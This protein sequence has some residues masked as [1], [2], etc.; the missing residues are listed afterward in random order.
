MTQLAPGLGAVQLMVT[1]ALVTPAALRPVGAPGSAGGA[2]ADKEDLELEEGIAPLRWAG[3][4]HADVTAGSRDSEIIDRS[5][6]RWW[7]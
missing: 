1:L 2:T 6:C 5:H 4:E 7:W 3:P